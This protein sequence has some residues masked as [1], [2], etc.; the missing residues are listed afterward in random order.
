VP[1]T[2]FFLFPLFFLSLKSLPAVTSIW[3]ASCTSKSGSTFL[4]LAI[5]WFHTR[6][7]TT[8]TAPLPIR[9]NC[10]RAL[11]RPASLYRRLS[12]SFSALPFSTGASP[13]PQLPTGPIQRQPQSHHSP[14][15]SVLLHTRNPTP[16]PNRIN[17]P[18]RR[19]TDLRA[20]PRPRRRRRRGAG[21]GWRIASWC[22]DRRWVVFFP[23]ERAA[24]VRKG[25]WLAGDVVSSPAG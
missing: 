25:R 3:V 11:L 20:L 21:R 7:S 16:I 15:P 24:C 12:S 14:P 22:L 5:P 9:P 10:F 19:H 8:T 1:L 6:N 17:H 23:C 4:S 2:V 18:R 13:L